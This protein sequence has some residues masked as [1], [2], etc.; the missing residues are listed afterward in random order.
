MVK[1]SLKINI[2]LMHFLSLLYYLLYFQRLNFTQLNFNGDL[3]IK[4][5][6]KAP[7]SF[8]SDSRRE[9]RKMP[10]PTKGQLHIN[11]IQAK[12]LKTDE[13]M[14]YCKMLVLLF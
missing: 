2:F 4:L 14:C 9:Q 3:I 7:G 5:N 8:V 12:D 6:Y 1:I 10:N 13:N 11:I